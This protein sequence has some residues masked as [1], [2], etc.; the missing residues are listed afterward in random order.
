VVSFTPCPLSPRQPLDSRLG[1]PP[2]PSG[3]R[4]GYKILD[5][6]WTRNSDAYTDCAAPALASSVAELRDSLDG[7]SAHCKA[8]ARTG[9]YDTRSGDVCAP[10]GIR[11]HGPNVRAI[12]ERSLF[13]PLLLLCCLSLLTDDLL[14]MAAPVS[15]IVQFMT[16][17][18]LY[19]T[20]NEL[21]FSLYILWLC[22]G[23]YVCCILCLLCFVGCICCALYIVFC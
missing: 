8:C 3:R 12:G 11:T 16:D 6:I 14:F 1:G 22:F 18:L 19:S 17:D 5:P 23:Y 9:Q 20:F 7:G 13:M 10:T 4:R 15:D 21:F 2:N